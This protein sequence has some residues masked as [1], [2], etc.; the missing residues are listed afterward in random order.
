M[1]KHRQAFS[2]ESVPAVNQDSGNSLAYVEF[3]S[4]IVAKIK[5]SDLVVGLDNLDILSC[6]L[7]SFELL[8]GVLSLLLQAIRGS[9]TISIVLSK[10]VG[11]GFRLVR[12]LGLGS[13]AVVNRLH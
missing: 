6:L 8:L 11:P 7:I 4:A 2:A 10:P 12:R 1:V 5:S 9:L 13:F 3:F